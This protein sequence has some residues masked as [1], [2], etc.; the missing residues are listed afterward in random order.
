[1]A[2]VE[3]ESGGLFRKE[4][5]E[6]HY[7]VRGEGA[8]LRLQPRWASWTFGVLCAAL[9]FAFLYSIVGSVHEYASGV[10]I[11]QVQGRREL[12]ARVSGTVASVEVQPG[13]RVAAGQVLARFHGDEVELE[14][15]TREHDLALV[16]VLDAP[17]D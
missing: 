14:R 12:T 10:A 15:L 7:G 2:L 16:K 4:A 8:A 9:G 13:Q 5:L 6:A 1:L 11:V 17:T 3:D